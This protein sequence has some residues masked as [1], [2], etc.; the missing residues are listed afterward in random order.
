MPKIKIGILGTANI[1]KK[2][3]IPTLLDLSNYFEIVGVGGRNLQRTKEFCESFDITSFKSYEELIQNPA[4]QAVYIPLPNAFHFEW[5]IKALDRGLHVMCEK[6]LG[7]NYEEVQIMVN[8]AREKKL[9]LME[10]FQFRFH[11]Q[12]E[13][14]QSRLH[15]IGEIRTIR[16]TFGIPPFGDENNI[17]YNKALGGG[18]L[19][20]NG[21][22]PIKIAQ[23]LMSES[24]NVEAC[25]LNSELFD[26]DIWGNLSI[27]DSKTGVCLQAAFGFDHVYSC[28][29]ELMGS[30]GRIY[31][32]RIYTAPPNHKANIMLEKQV[33]H[34]IEKEQVTLPEDDHFKNIWMY[35]HDMITTQKS[36]EVEYNQNL[37][38]SKLIDQAIVKSYDK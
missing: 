3:V 26:V 25:Q 17:R 30:K 32:D 19:L 11:K 29:L 8:K 27:K 31:T 22:Y 7:C 35:F 36:F 15:E 33:G 20:D 6:S 12:V 1:A 21:A 2:A 13:Y 10:H 38:Q 4:I 24:I 16:S 28:N 14:I 34:N 23:V 18:A 37:N 9:L 5:V